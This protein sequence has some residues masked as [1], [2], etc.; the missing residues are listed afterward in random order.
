MTENEKKLYDS[1]NK[2]AAA[3]KD[4]FEKDARRTQIKL[5]FFQ[6]FQKLQSLQQKANDLLPERQI[7]VT[8]GKAEFFNRSE[9]DTWTKNVVE[10]MTKINP[11]SK[12]LSDF[13]EKQSNLIGNEVTYTQFEELR[14][15]ARFFIE[16]PEL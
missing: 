2:E 8:S 3:Q 5:S 15:I 6:E 9:I 12:Y 10:V 1:L 7:S 4:Y 16:N 13:C 14:D 11:D